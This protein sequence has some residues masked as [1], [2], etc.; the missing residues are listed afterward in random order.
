M[1]I[2]QEGF[3]NQRRRHWGVYQPQ[4]KPLAL[5]LELHTME[6]QIDASSL[7]SKATY[8]LE[9]ELVP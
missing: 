9:T 6:M 7:T 8:V 1:D 4:L 2:F 3:L 5:I